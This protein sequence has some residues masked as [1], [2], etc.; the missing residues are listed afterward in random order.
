MLPST[1]A[2]REAV[3]DYYLSQ[4]P[5]A[6]VTFLQ[7]VYAEVLMGHRH[8]VWDVHASDGRWWIITNPTNLYS[9]DQFP[10]MDLAMTF[11]MGLC[12]RIPR[13]DK[14]PVDELD[15]TPFVDVLRLCQRF[16]EALDQAQDISGYRAIGVACRETL[17]AFVH[18]AQDAVDWTEDPPKRADL[19]GWVEVVLDAVL[20]GRDLRERRRLVK[21]AMEEA[22]V[23]CNWLTHSKS[24]TWHDAEAACRATAYAL[25][26]A[27]GM[28][29]RHLRQ[30]PDQCP[31]CSSRHLEP[32][33]GWSETDP[34][35]EWQR[36][37]CPDCGWTGAP[38]PLRERDPGEMIVREG[39][40]SDECS[41]MSVPLVGL[42]RPQ[43]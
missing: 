1:E 25:E 15:A 11:H 7:K 34:A 30:V 24:A 28:T 6:A 31:G 13:T 12:I 21:S 20:G 4:S 3:R 5:D 42:R 39:V 8:D 10:N 33:H 29:I 32:Q 18:A 41:I 43:P 14:R 17:L 16:D 23:F 38:T 35:I 27:I 40:T 36:P 2:E 9:Q 19:R 26:L 37:I 22:W